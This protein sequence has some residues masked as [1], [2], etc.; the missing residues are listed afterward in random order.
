MNIKKIA[1]GA[2]L[3]LVISLSPG[4]NAPADARDTTRADVIDWIFAYS[5]WYG[6]NPYQLL[7]VGECE[8]ELTPYALGKQGEVGPFQFHPRGIWWSTPQAAKGYSMWDVE[9]N[10]AAAAWAFSRGLQSHWTCW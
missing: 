3:A 7:R 6:A 2:G 5:Q 1:V 4:I 9:A 8:S 10:V